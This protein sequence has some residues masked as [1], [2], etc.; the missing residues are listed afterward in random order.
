[1]TS[2]ILLL[3]LLFPHLSCS[4]RFNSALKAVVFKARSFYQIKFSYGGPKFLSSTNIP[5]E[6][7][8]MNPLDAYP[9]SSSDDEVLESLRKE[10]M[11]N[12][13]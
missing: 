7:H 2:T 1:M 11:V 6:E 9:E 8:P 5:E 13:E 3:F 12:N 4:F 10:R